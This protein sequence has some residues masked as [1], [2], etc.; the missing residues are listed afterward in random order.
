MHLF[1]EEANRNLEQQAIERGENHREVLEDLINIQ[2]QAQLIWDKI[3]S[4]TNRIFAQHEEALLQYEQTLQKLVQINE[5]IQY[6]WNV[7]NVMRAEVDQKLSWLTSYIG[8]TGIY[9]NS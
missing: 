4:S 6:V 1:V 2:D 8:D 7:T 3:E 9:K 5:T